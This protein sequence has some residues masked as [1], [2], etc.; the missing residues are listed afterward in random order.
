ML[1]VLIYWL[2]ELNLVGVFFSLWGMPNVSEI[3]EHKIIVLHQ[4][5]RSLEK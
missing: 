3:D 1:K 5:G 4:Q 2:F